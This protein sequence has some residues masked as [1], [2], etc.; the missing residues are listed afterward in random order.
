MDWDE[1]NLSAIPREPQ[2][3]RRYARLILKSIS[4]QLIKAPLAKD[5]YA[6]SILYILTIALVKI[7]ALIFITRLVM[8]KV[9]LLVLWTMIGFVTL[10]G[11]AAVFAFAFQCGLSHPWNSRPTQCF[12]PVS[13][14][15]SYFEIHS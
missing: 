12:H 9:Y 3:C 5:I 1:A 8:K 6:S 15:V 7:A 14:I 11:L 2:D 10:W 4:T 13:H